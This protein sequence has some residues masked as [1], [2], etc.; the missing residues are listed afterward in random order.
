MMGSKKHFLKSEVISS[1]TSHAAHARKQRQVAFLLVEGFALTSFS[2]ALEAMNVANRIS[3]HTLYQT[4]ICA[5]RRADDPAGATGLRQGLDPIV[6]STHVPIA[7]DALITDMAQPDI[8]FICAYHG[9][10]MQGSPAIHRAIRQTLRAGGR[11]ASLSSGAFLLAAAGVLNEQGCVVVPEHKASFHELYP[12][13]PVH[14]HLYRV[15]GSIASC[16]GGVAALDML[17]F[18][19]AEDHGYAFADKVQHHFLQERMRTQDEYQHANRY[20]ALG[21]KSP[22]LR[23]AIQM[24]ESEIENPLPISAVAKAVGT[25]IRTLEEA[26][27]RY[28]NTTP[29]RYYLHIRLAHARKLVEETRMPIG[30]IA[31]ATGFTA[32]SHFTKRFR[33]AFARSPMQ[34]RQQTWTQSP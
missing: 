17:L 5:D 28:E 33:E 4:C 19:I 11:V 3:G 8:L 23:A 22:Y 9:A 32:Q 12:D 20:H 24:M 1:V 34:M 21:Q 29:S 16:A 25:S 15:T 31:L 7:P 30:S 27:R 26:F 6:S 10:A 2:L 18:I 13:I 14:D